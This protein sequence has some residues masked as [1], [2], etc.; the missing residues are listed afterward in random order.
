MKLTVQEASLSRCQVY[1]FIIPYSLILFSSLYRF[2]QE[3]RNQRNDKNGTTPIEV[4]CPGLDLYGNFGLASLLT[5][6]Y[7]QESPSR[8]H[9]PGFSERLQQIFK[10]SSSHKPS[11][12]SGKVPTLQQD[13]SIPDQ[14][15]KDLRLRQSNKSKTSS[16]QDRVLTLSTSEPGAGHASSH[17]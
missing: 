6:Q 8:S 1:F 9:A 11:S 3:V 4:V 17:S 13:V 15:L 5:Q 10:P 2:V 16:R 14:S 7:G 12:S